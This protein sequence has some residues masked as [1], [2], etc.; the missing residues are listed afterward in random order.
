ML[1]HQCRHAAFVDSNFSARFSAP[2]RLCVE[3]T[4]TAYATICGIS[5][6]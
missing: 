4:R 1:F 6:P 2:L 5:V 3:D